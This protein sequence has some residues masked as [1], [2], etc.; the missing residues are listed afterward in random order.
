MKNSYIQFVNHASIYLNDG[1]I[2]LL[3]DPWYSGGAFNNGWELIY[4]NNDIEIKKI[5]DKTQYIWI[6]HEH[7]DHF[8][9]DFFKNYKDLIIKKNIKIIF[10]NTKD[11][12]V[13]SF[14]NN[15]KISFIELEDFKKF[16]LSNNFSLCIKKYDFY[17]SALFINLQGLKIFNLNDC[18]INDVHELNQ[19]KKKFGSCDILLTQFSYA[20]W[21]GGK[22]N[23]KWRKKAAEEKL[24]TIK[25]QAQILNA[26]TVMPFASFIRFSNIY[27]DH[28]NDSVNTP[29][30]TKDKLK[31]LNSEIIFMRPYETQ[32]A[33]NIK[34]DDKSLQFWRELYANKKNTNLYVKNKIFK[35]EEINLEFKK[36]CERIYSKNSEIIIKILFTLKFFGIFQI[37]NIYLKD[38]DKTLSI[39]II[40]RKI[41]Y[42]EK[43]KADIEMLSDSLMFIFKYT[44]GF[45]TLTVNGCFEE[46]NK[47]GFSKMSKLFALENLN[48]LGYKLDYKFLSNYKLILLFLKKL[49][50]VQKKINLD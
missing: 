2:G 35:I 14:F 15:Y 41:D 17:D 12:R 36:Y 1:D 46:K 38:L 6:S 44:Y 25:K 3:T 5:L 42:T 50:S 45:D 20:A 24:N 10:Q 16:G 40:K 49:F 27:N 34:Q 30:E 28:L 8:S 13:C 21:K 32:F 29:D 9:V 31:N 47:N 23:I 43:P 39:D 22:D 11:K 19:I 37:L 48:N 4:E 26:K 18:P 7:P 33:N